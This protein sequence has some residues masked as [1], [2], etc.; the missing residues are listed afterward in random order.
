MSKNSPGTFGSEDFVEALKAELLEMSFFVFKKPREVQSLRT[1]IWSFFFASEAKAYIVVDVLSA[2]FA[3]PF[4]VLVGNWSLERQ[5]RFIA[6][7][8]STADFWQTRIQS[9]GKYPPIRFGFKNWGVSKRSW[10][11]TMWSGNFGVDIGSWITWILNY[12][13]S[14]NFHRVGNEHRQ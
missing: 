6:K 14:F 11:K 12:F 4:H 3:C 5:F 13:N 9:K 2:R 1:F 10:F 7:M 8:T